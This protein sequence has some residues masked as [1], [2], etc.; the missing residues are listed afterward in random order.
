MDDWK[1]GKLI[2][3]VRF[4]TFSGQLDWVSEHFNELDI[5]IVLNTNKCEKM[6]PI[7]NYENKYYLKNWF[8]FFRKNS[9]ARFSA[10]VQIWLVWELKILIDQSIS[11]SEI[12][13]DHKIWCVEHLV[14]LDV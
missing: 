6:Q 9:H 14:G 3:Y 10:D 7:L 8:V 12:P 5:K 2:E 13:V 11:G 4:D 1:V